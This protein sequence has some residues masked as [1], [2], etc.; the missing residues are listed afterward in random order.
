MKGWEKTHLYDEIDQHFLET[1]YHNQKKKKNEGKKIP[2]WTLV[3]DD[4]AA[5]NFFHN[6]K[7]SGFSNIL[8]VS[9]RHF[10]LNTFVLSQAFKRM[11]D[12]IQRK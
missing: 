2:I 10:N 8:A 6:G 5:D 11:M 9:G 3:F 1:L 12:T 4:N 7:P